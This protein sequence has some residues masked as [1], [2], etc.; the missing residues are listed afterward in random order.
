MSG[1]SLGTSD[2]TQSSPL[3]AER[4]PLSKDVFV[5][6]AS[7]DAAVA[8]AVVEALERQ[9]IRCWIAPRDVTPGEFYADAIVHA[10]DATQ[11]LILVLSRHAAVS[12]H[13]LREVERATSKRHPVISLRIDRAVL[14]AGLEYFLNTSQWLDASEGNVSRA[15]PK[16]VE[17]VR[18]VLGSSTTG[19]G[20]DGGSLPP[21]HEARATK[22]SFNRS[23]AVVVG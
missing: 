8:N 18:K 12:H 7:Q 13:I 1:D 6:Y 9:G 17:A 21:H 16:L 20:D 15:L 5:S 19:S 4:P 23:L 11:A 14:P 3:E 10:I 2:A 22:R